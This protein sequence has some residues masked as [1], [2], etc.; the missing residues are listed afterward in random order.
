MHNPLSFGADFSYRNEEIGV[1]GRAN[2][3]KRPA[4]IQVSANR[5]AAGA[6]LNGPAATGGDVLSETAL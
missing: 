6:L 3:S 4:L 1:K 5:A 2:G